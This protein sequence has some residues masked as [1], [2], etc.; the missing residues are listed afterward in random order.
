M[1][2]PS[3]G[4]WDEGILKSRDIWRAAACN[5]LAAIQALMQSGVDVNTRNAYGQTALHTA[6]WH[7]FVDIM[8]FLIE[9]HADVNVA[10]HDGQ[11][12]LHWA[13]GSGFV[14]A[15]DLLVTKGA[16]INCPDN[17]EQVP[18]HWAATNGKRDVVIH[19]LRMGAS[20]ASRN[21]ENETPADVA[22]TASIR[23]ILLLHFR[24]S[25]SPETTQAIIHA[26]P[27]ESPHTIAAQMSQFTA[28]NQFGQEIVLPDHNWVSLSD[29]LD[30]ISLS[31]FEWE[32]DE[33]EVTFGKSIGIGGF[34][35]V[36]E[37]T[38]RGLTVAVKRLVPSRLSERDI[39]SFKAEVSIMSK[40]RHPNILL[41]LG[42]SIQMPNLF[43]V[44]EHC[45]KGALYD[46]LHDAS[47]K[48]T[49][50]IIQSVAIDICRGINY[51]HCTR[52]PHPII[53][54][55]IKS[56]N[57][58]VDKHWTIKVADFGHTKFKISTLPMSQ[59]G[60]V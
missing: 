7:G 20:P 32:L 26:L 28:P 60:F 8:R 57:L 51:L 48:L 52:R 30:N 21:V 58:L 3:L 56:L 49:P 17:D 44:T 15:V 33:D 34:G 5:N 54:R 38:W 13:S 10:D 16:L 14:E 11:T 25:V 45:E 2:A 29:D 22:K 37:G 1:E 41:F 9:H 23:D 19:L 47:V 31:G 24:D 42:A 55:D 50:S 6:S 4:L 53:H 46:V 43:V 40:L 18:L 59:C 39:K 35:E 36:F 12:P 27:T